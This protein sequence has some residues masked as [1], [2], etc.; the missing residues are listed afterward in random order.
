M[1]TVMTG[2]IVAALSAIGCSSDETREDAES[3][4]AD[5]PEST[6]AATTVDGPEDVAPPADVD[7]VADTLTR[8]ERAIRSPATPPDDVPRVGWEQQHAYR[9]LA[10]H[11]EWAAQVLDAVPPDV[12]PAVAANEQA[13]REV[14]TLAEPQPTLPEWRI[15][16]PPPPDVLIGFYREAEAS[17]GIPWPYLAAIHL[18]ET[19]VGRIRGTSTAGAQGPMQFI[20]TTWAAYGE[21]DVNDNR[22]AILAAGRYLRASGG[23]DDMDA[24]LHAYN[25]SN[26]YVRAIQAYAGVIRASELAY[27]GYYY[28]QVYYATTDGVALLPEGYPREEA[29]SDPVT[30]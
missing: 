1:R 6:T 5:A 12:R 7:E 3:R 9:V 13:V 15:E 26:S 28:W 4:A 23:P 27:Q 11:P 22:D 10:A 17:S 14:G 25:P 18:V 21:G 2:L 8:V 19:R 29:V 30:G 20:P 24:A 16:A